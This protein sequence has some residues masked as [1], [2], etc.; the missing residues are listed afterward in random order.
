MSFALDGTFTQ[1]SA[2]DDFLMISVRDQN[3]DA[4]GYAYNLTTGETIYDLSLDSAPPATGAITPGADNMFLNDFTIFYGA[5]IFAFAAGGL[6]TT[7]KAD[8]TAMA[9][10]LIAAKS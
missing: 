7:W 3:V 4:Y 1:P 6:P 9:R 5:A 2:G 10:T 8:M